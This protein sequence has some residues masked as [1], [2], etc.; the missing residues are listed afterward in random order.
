[1]KTREKIVSTALRLFNERGYS[2]VTTRHI[3]SEL[4]ISAGNLHYHFKHSEDIV[5]ELFM[6]LKQEMDYTINTL[7]ANGSKDLEA[8]YQYTT[9]T[10]EVVYA[11]R[12]IFLNFVDILRQIPDI[13][14]LYKELNISRKKEFLSVFSDFQRNKVFVENIPDFILDHMVTQI[15][16]IGDNWMNYNSLTLKL[17]KEDALKHYIPVFLN[18]FYPWLTA[19]QQKLYQQ[20]YIR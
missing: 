4:N 5:K 6:M 10:F 20:K 11:F 1:M 2:T 17:N 13:E 8:L 9:S 15:F 16:I 14:N 12:C 7:K 19:D 18:L 3:A